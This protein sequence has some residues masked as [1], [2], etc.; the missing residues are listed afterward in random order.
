MPE[1]KD[2]KKEPAKKPLDMTSDEAIE[3]LFGQEG[4]QTLKQYVREKI[5]P[6]PDE[7]ESLKRSAKSSRKHG[8][9]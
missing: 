4:A 6:P 8:S 3:F 7:D 2:E 9:K 1:K 5:D